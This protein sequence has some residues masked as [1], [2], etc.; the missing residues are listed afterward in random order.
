MKLGQETEAEG[1]K[2]SEICDEPTDWGM[3]TREDISEEA[4]DEPHAQEA[5]ARQL[6]KTHDKTLSEGMPVNN[7]PTPIS[8][9]DSRSMSQAN[10]P[11][12]STEN[13][14]QVRQIIADD[15]GQH[16][17]EISRRTARASKYS[18]PSTTGSPSI[19]AKSSEPIEFSQG[20]VGVDSLTEEDVIIAYVHSVGYPPTMIDLM[21]YAV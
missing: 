6:T 21:D 14:S 18:R 4:Q 11:A 16:L 12:H 3:P 5:Q 15:L 10:K 20:G 8:S 9:E 1:L 19:R 17:P 2:A 13:P 7:S